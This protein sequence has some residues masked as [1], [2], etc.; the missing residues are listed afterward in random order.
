MLPRWNKIFVSSHKSYNITIS[1]VL[2]LSVSGGSLACMWGLYFSFPANWQ[3]LISSL[4]S[5]CI[6]LTIFACFLTFFFFS[7]KALWCGM[8]LSHLIGKGFGELFPPW[9]KWYTP[10]VLPRLVNISVLL[11]SVPVP[12]NFVRQ[13]IVIDS[14]ETQHHFLLFSV[15]SHVVALSPEAQSSQSFFFFPSISLSPEF[16]HLSTNSCTKLTENNF[17]FWSSHL[18]K[19]VQRL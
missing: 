4:L 5:F 2:V 19:M 1:N 11:S 13:S 18:K 6:L 17:Q 7:P 12:E 16:L 10:A 9:G 14:R 15:L 3:E 8:N